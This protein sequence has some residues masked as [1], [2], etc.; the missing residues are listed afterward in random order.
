VALVEALRALAPG[1]QAAKLK[2][3]ND[4]LVGEAKAAGIL[5]EGRMVGE[6]RQAVVLGIGVNV[7]TAPSGLPYPVTAL[8]EWVKGLTAESL[9]TALADVFAEK[10]AL[11]DEG[12][13]SAAIL[14]DWQAH[15]FTPGAPLAIRREAGSLSGRYAG[16]D[17]EGR[18]LLET[19]E[20]RVAIEAGD[21][22]FVPRAA[23]A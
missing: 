8:A 6:G 10:L 9:F 11:F 14:R 19:A 2:W 4:L 16:L 3:P 12:R 15:S 22:A 7:A 13:G 18:L 20:G 23:V 21:V 17:E 5:L 1:L